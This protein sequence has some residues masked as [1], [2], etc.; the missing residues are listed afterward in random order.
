[1]T[2]SILVDVDDFGGRETVE[3]G[4][5]GVAIGTDVLAIDQIAEVEVGQFLG[6]RD[7]VERVAGGAEDGADLRRAFL[8]RLY[9]IFA[10]VKDDA[11]VGVIDAIVNVVAAAAVAVGF[12]DDL[13]DG[14][15]GGGDE[16][17]AGFGEDLDV[18]RE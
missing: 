18:L 11:G 14:G 8:E 16:E 9:R 15:A 1:M 6:Q 10:V 12:A 13:R 4:A 17:A 3:V 5:G 7:R 2:P